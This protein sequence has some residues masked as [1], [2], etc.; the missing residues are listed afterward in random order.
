MR[1]FRWRRKCYIYAMK[2]YLFILLTT[3]SYCSFGQTIRTI[4]SIGKVSLRGLSVVNNKIIWVS[5]SNGTVGLSKDAGNSWKWMTVKGFEH[6]DFRDVEAFDDKI[7]IIMGIASPAYILK[8]TDGGQNW[9]VVYENNDAA[10]FLDAMEFWNDMSGIV[11]GDPQNGRFFIGRTF[12]GGETWQTIPDRYKPEAVNGEA[13]FAASGTN[14]R[15]YSKDEAVFVTGGKVSDFFKRDKKTSLPLNQGKPTTGANSLA[16]KKNTI[17]VVG[18]DFTNPEATGGNCVITSDGG[19]TWKIPVTPP[20]GYRSCIEYI[21]KDDWITCGLNGV[22]YSKDNGSIWQ[23][24]SNS[25]FHVVRKAKK[26]NAVFL[27]GDDGRVAKL[28]P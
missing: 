11:I 2:K 23:K 15:A 20:S 24:I 8:T 5:G 12:D 7:A 10:M 6:T 19:L 1:G 28:M 21:S 13:C 25:P 27:A 14:I 4:D 18:G 22:D 26:G 9:K 17:I 3:W 16:V